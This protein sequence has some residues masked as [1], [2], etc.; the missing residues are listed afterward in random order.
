MQDSNKCMTKQNKTKEIA[1]NFFVK[2]STNQKL[3]DD[4][5]P[6]AITKQIFIQQNFN[7]FTPLAGWICFTRIFPKIITP[8]QLDKIWKIAHIIKEKFVE[9][10]EQLPNIGFGI[11]E[12]KTWV[13]DITDV[14]QIKNKICLQLINIMIV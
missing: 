6:Q 14:V 4:L 2:T 13:T 1:W 9:S 3:L 11:N 5:F 7:F 8:F 12:L 10:R